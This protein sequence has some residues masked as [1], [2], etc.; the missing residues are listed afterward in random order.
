MSKQRIENSFPDLSANNYSITSPATTEYNCIAWAAGDTEKWWWPDPLYVD[1]WPSEAPRTDS[2]QS[3]IKAYETLDYAVCDSV[4]YEDGFE[5][6][7]IYVDYAG[8]PTHV[9]R[10]LSS[11]YWTSKLGDWEDIE[12]NVLNSI[13]GSQ[14]GSVA[15]ILKRPTKKPSSS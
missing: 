8:K 15:T 9:A 14:Y 10:Q 2:L 6:V 7:A 1:Y 5:K 11:G 4:V 3:F 12:H 13:I